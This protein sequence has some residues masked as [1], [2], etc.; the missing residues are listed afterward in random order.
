MKTH[1]DNNLSKSGSWES[2]LRIPD[3]I[4]LFFKQVTASWRSCISSTSDKGL[5]IQWC[6]SLNK[7]EKLIE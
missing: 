6:N 4:E 5:Q 2:R 1:F 7:Q 3:E